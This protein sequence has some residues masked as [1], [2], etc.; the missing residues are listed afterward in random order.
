MESLRTK[1]V[2]RREIR[3]ITHQ[4]TKKQ[5]GTFLAKNGPFASLLDLEIS[6]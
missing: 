6:S 1:E 3:K 5:N 2:K 4:E